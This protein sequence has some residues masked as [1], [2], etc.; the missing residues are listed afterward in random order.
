MGSM[1]RTWISS[2]ISR[3][4]QL[5]ARFGSADLVRQPDGSYELIGGTTDDVTQAKEWISLFLND[6]APVFL[7]ERKRAA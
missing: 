1:N 7:G 5:V 4:A 2:W 6:T 3:K